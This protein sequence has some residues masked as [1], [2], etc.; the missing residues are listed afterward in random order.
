MRKNI[1][2]V[3]ISGVLCNI[4]VLLSRY[5]E[6]RYQRSPL[7]RAIH[8]TTNANNQSDQVNTDQTGSSGGRTSKLINGMTGSSESTNQADQVMTGQKGQAS[9]SSRIKDHVATGQTGLSDQMASP[10][11]TKPPVWLITV[12]YKSEMLKTMQEQYYNLVNK[13]Y[14]KVINVRLRFRNEFVDGKVNYYV[15]F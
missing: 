14:S 4:F 5:Q 15:S 2:V 6:S 12:Y 8:H 10:T 1:K 7:Y 3:L 11:T 13:R 9:T